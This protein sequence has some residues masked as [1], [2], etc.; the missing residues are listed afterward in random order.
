MKLYE[1]RLPK[2]YE[3]IR[4]PAN[5]PTAGDV[6]VLVNGRELPLEPSLAV[7]RHSPTGF[8]WGYSGSGPRQLA[9]AILLDYYQDRDK[10][11]RLSG[12]FNQHVVSRWEPGKNWTI[13]S[14]EID[15]IC[16]QIESRQADAGTNRGR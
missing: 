14:A 6:T 13:T 11:L 2:V 5:L 15:A 10:A 12:E 1:M 4:A 3:G 9:L 7:V 8:N 16:K